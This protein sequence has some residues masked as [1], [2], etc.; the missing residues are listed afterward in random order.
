[1]IRNTTIAFIA[2][3][4][5]GGSAEAGKVYKWVDKDGNVHYTNTPPPEASQ[6][7]RE[8]LD[9]SG[10]VTETL[11]APKTPEEIEAERRRQAEAAEQERL[12]KEQA[13]RD[14][15]LL[16]TYTSVEEMKMARDGRIAALDAQVNV[17]S[18]TISALETQLA[19][20]EQQ[21]ANVRNAGNP[22]PEQL[23]ARIEKTRDELLEN[24]K[25]LIA[26]QQEQEQIREK[27]N[28]DIARF[29]ELKG[30]Q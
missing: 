5:L 2:A 8:V 14:Q 1:M 28:A 10:R 12:A 25:F 23:Q 29:R 21:A 7:E 20:L 26:R 15:M 22:V 11:A 24:Q 30:E 3:L 27:F 19:E 17:V 9:E 6:T 13:A 18:G 4:V 16:Q